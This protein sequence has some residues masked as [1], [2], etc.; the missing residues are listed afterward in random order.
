MKLNGNKLGLKK[1]FEANIPPLIASAF[2]WNKET[3]ENYI[4][5]VD[6]LD[7]SLTKHGLKHA[8][9]IDFYQVV[10]A[11]NLEAKDPR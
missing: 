4:Q 6:H 1:A 11:N 8:G 5:F 3:D 10:G 7:K 2:P 9:V